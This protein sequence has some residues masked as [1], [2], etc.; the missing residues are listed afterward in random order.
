[1]NSA[2]TWCTLPNSTGGFET[3]PNNGTVTVNIAENPT[4]EERAATITLTSGTLTQQVTVTQANIDLI[5]EVAPAV[6]PAAATAGSYAIAVTSNTTWTASVNSAATWCTLPNSTG[7]F[8][9]RPNNGT[10]TVNVAE[11]PTAE[12]RV[13]TVTF[14]AGTLTQQ[15]AITQ[16]GIILIASGT[17]GACSWTISGTTGSYTLTI[18]GNGVM[19][20]YNYDSTPWYNYQSGITTVVIQDGVPTIGENAFYRCTGLTNVTI[21]NSVTTIGDLAFYYCSKLTSVTIPNSVTTI[22]WSAFS[23]CTGLTN[24]TI[25]NSVTAVGG[26]AFEDCSGLTGTLTIPNSVTSIGEEAFRSCTGLTEVT[27]PNSVTTIG[28]FA[29]LNCTGLTGINVD[30]DNSTYTSAD[31]VLFNKD[32]TTLVICPGGKAG[33]YVIPNSVT[34]FDTWTFAGCSGLTEVTIPNSVTTIGDGT[35]EGCTGLTEVTIPN[36]VTAIGNYA[37]YG[38]TGLTEVTIPNSVTTIGYDAFRECRGLTE[39]TIDMTTISLHIIFP[40]CRNL[41]NVTIGNSVTTI[42]GSDRYSGLTNINVD[43]GNPNY[44][45]EDGVLF[46]KDKTTLVICPRGKTGNYIIPN[47]VTTIGSSAFRDCTGLTEVTIPNSVTYING[48]AF[49]GCTGLTNINVDADNS[50]YTSADG[51]LFNKNKTTLVICPGGKTGNYI[52]PNSVTTIGSSAFYGCTGLTEVTI[53]SSVS[54]I[55]GDAFEGCTGLTNVTNLRTRPQSIGSSVFS[56]TNI[57][58]GTLRVPSSAVNAY[59]ASDWNYYFGSIVGI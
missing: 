28:K 38:C 18:S 13:A 29:F 43:A 50:T 4:I 42:G 41:T 46:N 32:K 49:S 8:E 40:D 34:T 24:V 19:G 27:I 39:V 51:V 33:N 56:S 14:S 52:I 16:Q 21:P 22:G 5:L 47:S 45:S 57:S 31:G 11:N 48:S 35:F 3:R 54:S 36:S 2:A 53:P 58:S 9:T 44:S 10:V 59:K 25:P 15:V 26:H 37:F 1:V 17:T 12:E 6:I 55:R 7:G 30:A 20:Y 23:G